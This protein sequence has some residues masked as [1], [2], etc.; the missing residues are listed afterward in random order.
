LVAETGWDP[1]GSELLVGTSAGA[2]VAALTASGAK[3]WD[4]LAPDRQ[5]LLRAL[6]EG[7][8]FRVEF[9]L[10]SSA[11]PS[12]FWPVRTLLHQQL[13]PQMRAVE[14]TG[15]RLVV[16]EPDGRSIGLIGLNPMSR[17]QVAEVGVAAS[18]EVRRYVQQPAVRRKLAGLGALASRPQG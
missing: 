9:R 8:T 14:G 13:V 4:A 1:A 6:M 2:V 3:P 11:Q 17:R 12:V 5:D 10:K 7:A 16:I 15:I 18:A